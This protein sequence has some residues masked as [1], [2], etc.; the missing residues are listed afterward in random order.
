MRH[1]RAKIVFIRLH[2]QM[3]HNRGDQVAAS[4][5]YEVCLRKRQ[6]GLANDKYLLKIEVYCAFL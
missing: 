2:S 5:E 1:G 6:V 4:G 3:R